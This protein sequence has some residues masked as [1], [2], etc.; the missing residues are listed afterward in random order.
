[1]L[2]NSQMALD[3]KRWEMVACG[4]TPD[5]LEV[6]E[7]ARRVMTSSSSSSQVVYQPHSR[8]HPGQLSPFPPSADAT[9]N[10]GTV[11]RQL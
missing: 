3:Y 8:P 2:D 1:M 11:L 9:G 7:Q 6:T 10:H 5:Q 4:R